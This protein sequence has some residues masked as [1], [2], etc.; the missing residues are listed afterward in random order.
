M[1]LDVQMNIT[2]KERSIS[3]L[4]SACTNYLS[5]RILFLNS[6][7][8]DAGVMAHE[9]LEKVLKSYLYFK[10]PTSDYSSKHNI[11]ELSNII[12][13]KYIKINIDKE[14]IHFFENC[15]TYRYPDNPKKATT[16]RTGSD[17]IHLLD[18]CFM[19]IHDLCMN[20]IQSDELRNQHGIFLLAEKYFRTGDAHII[21]TLLNENQELP[22][23]IIDDVRISWM[24]KGFY[25]LDENGLMRFPN[26]TA[27][28]KVQ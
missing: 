11:F 13:R 17:Y 27:S 19:T 14:D 25:I 5:S 8:F 24:N 1:T 16:F 20:E 9:T 10:E 12:A 3:F 4:D 26:G 15:Y 6:Q 2:P 18:D 22:I 23:K 7:I 21:D 28:R